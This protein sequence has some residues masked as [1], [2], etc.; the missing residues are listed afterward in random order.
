MSGMEENCIGS[1]SPPRTVEEEEEEEKKK[2]KKMM[3]LKEW[4]C[5]I[6]FC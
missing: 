3:I 1:Q 5:N 4:L 6:H 2:K